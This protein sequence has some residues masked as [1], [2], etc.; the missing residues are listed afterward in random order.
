MSAAA[1]SI[2]ELTAPDV[3]NGT[4]TD[5]AGKRVTVIGAARSGLAAA[6]LL[7][8]NGAV[9][10]VSD[11]SPAEKLGSAVETLRTLHIASEFGGHTP[12]VFEAGM[13]VV[14]P[15]VPSTIPVLKE[16][17]AR[18]LEIIS[19]LELASRLCP[20][21]IIAITG[22]NGKTTVTTL[23]GR[24]FHDA[25][26]KHVVAGNIGTS[27]SALVPELDSTSVAVLEVS[28]F[29]L[30]GTSTF[31]PHVSVLLNITPDHLDR[32]DGRMEAYVDAKCRIFER[33]TPGDWLI[34]NN[35]D[36]LVRR[37]AEE[38]ARSKTKVLPFGL[39][40]AGRDGAFVEDGQLMIS[41]NG[42]REPILP[43]DE[44]SIRGIH[45][46]YN[47]MAATLAGRVMGI[48]VPSLRA[49]LR[50]FKGVEHRLEFVR[51]LDGVIYINDSKAT[52]IDSVWYALQA[53]D[54]PIVL[55]LGGRDK[56]ND[57]TRLYDL[58]AKHVKAIVSIGESAGK[59]V[60][61]FS[62]RVKTVRADSMAAA[63]SGGRA[64]AE[65]GDIVLLSPACAS[66]DWFENYEHR[67]RVFKQL[68]QELE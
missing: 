48:S 5:L 36:G 64:L 6:K 55:L 20:A 41:I 45:N 21:P 67:G 60:D 34:Y 66:F 57:Y 59:V 49:T 24:M 11:S 28:S 38:R 8:D 40:P 13:I 12:S 33:Q 25:R 61:A 65:P 2:E 23:T 10:F 52:N 58:V 62:S 3:K 43:T 14:S 53:Y 30:D 19:E 9:V 7:R 54:R 44:I 22:T 18:G 17:A 35:D 1:N 4:H 47:A 27:F 29:Q 51:T 39:Q 15:G 68:V 63:V 56:G 16:A 26:R 37:C 50:N 32:Y 46:L 31:H 42:V